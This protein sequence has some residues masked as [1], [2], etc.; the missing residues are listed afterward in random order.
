MRWT[1]APAAFEGRGVWRA[2]ALGLTL[3]AMALFRLNGMLALVILGGWF[4]IAFARRR[5]WRQ[6]AAMTL[7][8]AVLMGGVYGYCFGP[9]N[10]LNPPNGFSMQAV[11][12]GL[13]AIVNDPGITQDELEEIGAILPVD[14]MREH[15]VRGDSTA[16]LWTLS[17]DNDQ[18]DENDRIFSNHFVL[19]LGEHRMEAA[20]LYLKLLPKHL[21]VCVK[22]ILA[23]TRYM[24]QLLAPLFRPKYFYI[25]HGM[26]V[27]LLILAIASALRRGAGA[28]ILLPFAPAALNIA[29]IVISAVTLEMRYVVPTAILFVPLLFYALTAPQS[30]P[31]RK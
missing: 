22:D 12:S 1:D 19:Q 17:E 27:M 21:G 6:A 31:R 15:Y 20:L 9:L 30:N 24:W 26:L 10:A 5:L 18:W 16:L 23:N 13:A 11:G 14:W 8:A 25:G 2:A 4:L 7:C 29:S 3:A 28:R